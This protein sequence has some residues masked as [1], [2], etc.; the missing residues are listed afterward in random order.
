MQEIQK[1]ILARGTDL[2]PI[3]LNQETVGLLFLKEGKAKAI[4]QHGWK[5]KAKRCYNLQL[6]W[7][8][9]IVSLSILCLFC[10]IF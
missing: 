6:F 10:D 2:V 5:S 9:I 8:S 4:Y 7:M 3:L 1:R